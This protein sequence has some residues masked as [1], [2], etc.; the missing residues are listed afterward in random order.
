MCTATGF[1]FF[2]EELIKNGCKDNLIATVIRCLDM[3]LKLPSNSLCRI[4][5]SI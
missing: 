3:R 1:K 2:R 5:V 4:M